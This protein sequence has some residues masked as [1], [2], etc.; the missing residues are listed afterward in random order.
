MSIKTI[1]LAWAVVGIGVMLFITLTEW[2]TGFTILV[3][4]SGI[5]W[6]LIFAI[7]RID[8][9]RLFQFKRKLRSTDFF[10]KLDSTQHHNEQT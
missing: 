7:S 1:L 4:F 9:S 6:V 8:D 2:T 10:R 5:T 3:I